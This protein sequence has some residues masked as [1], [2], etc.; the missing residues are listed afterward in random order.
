MQHL[1]I[2]NLY[3]KQNKVA[4]N[5]G[6]T[7]IKQSLFKVYWLSALSSFVN[8]DSA[9]DVCIV[10]ADYAVYRLYTKFPGD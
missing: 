8:N 4:I 9:V 6:L 7:I 2:K 10:S 5:Q 1:L 3:F